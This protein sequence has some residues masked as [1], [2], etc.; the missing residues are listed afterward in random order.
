MPDTSLLQQI[1]ATADSIG[2]PSAIAIEQ[3]RHESG[4]FRQDVIY[5]PSIGGAG[6]RG[7]AQFI[8]GTWARFGSGDPYNPANSLQA[9]ARY[10]SYLASLFNGDLRRIL[11][12]YNGGEGNVQRGTVSSAARNYADGIL[13]RAGQGSSIPQDPSVIPYD[14]EPSETSIFN[15]SIFG[16]SPILSILAIASAAGLVVY[17]IR[18]DD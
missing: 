16:L 12:A 2:F 9:W 4:N 13:A 14:Q 15:V 6:E 18:Q 1:A 11:Q 7:L 3:L 8:P 17:A 5:G 10:T